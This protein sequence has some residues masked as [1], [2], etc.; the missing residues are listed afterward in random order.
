MLTLWPRSLTPGFLLNGPL[1]L[2]GLKAGQHVYVPL[3]G[4]GL[5]VEASRAAVKPAGCGEWRPEGG[6]RGWRP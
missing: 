2:D 6:S 1:R 5:H 4:A 3:G